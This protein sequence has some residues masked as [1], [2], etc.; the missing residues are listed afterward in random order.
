MDKTETKVVLNHF[1]MCTKS[2]LKFLFGCGSSLLYFLKIKLSDFTELMYERVGG[3]ALEKSKLLPLP[4]S[5][6]SH[7]AL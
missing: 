3:K 7:N 6:I 1:L 5:Y 4:L 2:G